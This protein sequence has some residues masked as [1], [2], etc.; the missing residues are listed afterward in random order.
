M[1]QNS[2]VVEMGAH[3][4]FSRLLAAEDVTVLHTDDPTASFDVVKRVL[5]L[6]RWDVSDTVYSW[7]IVHEVGHALLTP[8]DELHTAIMSKEKWERPI[9]AQVLNVVE[10]VRV[11]RRQKRKFPGV[12]TWY[13]AAA[14]EAVAEDL[15]QLSKVEDVNKMSFVDRINLYFK[16]GI[17][18]LSDVS[19]TDEEIEIVERIRGLEEF[20]EVVAEAEKLFERHKQDAQK[21]LTASDDSGDSAG[22]GKGV[23][24]IE[25]SG[26]ELTDLL[27]KAFRYGKMDV[28]SQKNLE[29]AVAATIVKSTSHVEHIVD[30]VKNVVV[31]KSYLGLPDA[32]CFRTAT[33]SA[34]NIS[35][36]VSSFERRKR[37]RAL[38]KVGES[39]TGSID[40]KRLWSF[41]TEDDIFLRRATEPKH[42]N[43]GFV[44]LIDMSGS[45]SDSQRGVFYQAWLT[46]S[47]ARRIGVPFEIY[48]FSS[49]GEN[50][51]V[52]GSHQ[53]TKFCT[54][55]ST[56]EEIV[57]LLKVATGSSSIAQGG[58]PL[59]STMV[60]M[61]HL[62][63]DFRR[64]TGV[65]V[66]NFF[67][68][69][70]GECDIS[71]DD[72]S[73]F[74]DQKTKGRYS[75]ELS[76]HGGMNLVPGMLRFMK[77]HT[78]AR[79]TVFYITDEQKSEGKNYGNFT[80]VEGKYGADTTFFVRSASFGQLTNRNNRVMFDKIV[81]AMA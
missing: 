61:V 35:F 9:F 14:E 55:L 32:G 20:H 54:N 39:K 24:V 28:K 72:K 7:L 79:V 1:K 68:L 2:G 23:D 64:R 21:I 49:G 50:K 15:F 33:D 13:A 43:H 44:L 78:G 18:D 52:F 60:S 67:L 46:A 59:T 37:A 10:D 26:D 58:T 74:I 45:M 42:T 11:D 40:T 3:S 75:A 19:F 48:G 34:A 81:E 53:L 80:T 16:L 36:M 51:N 5:R 29:K 30:P 22:D 71:T 47:F 66:M 69:S 41:M 25:V 4:V 38:E 56:P 8:P 62:V 65:D 57:S 63:D 73:S 17:Y 27:K 77:D 76:Y 31:T 70:D 6:P 12:K